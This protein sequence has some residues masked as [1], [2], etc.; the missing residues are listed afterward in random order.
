VYYPLFSFGLLKQKSAS[1]WSPQ[2]T[3]SMVLSRTAARILD[4]IPRERITRLVGRAAERPV[5]STVLNPVLGAYIRAFD[6]NLDEAVVPQDGFASFNDFFTR[7][8]RD[9][10]HAIDQNPDAIVSPSDGRL[11]D[12]GPI[13]GNSHFLVKG[14]PY[15][16]EELLGSSEEA[17]WFEG[18]KYGVVYL[19]PRDYHRVH[20][21]VT[22]TVRRVRH[23]PG[24]LYPVNSI[25]IRH[26][27][28]LF[29]RNER[30]VVYVDTERFGTVAVVFVGAFIVGKISLYFDAP[31]R[32]PH[33][34]SPV[35]RTY[36]S[37]S[38]PRLARGDEMGAF[39]LGSTVVLLLPKSSWRDAP[40][41]PIGPVRMGQPI[42][43]RSAE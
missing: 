39:L 42:A 18:G 3:M 9:G 28:R 41:S 25:G 43:W 23:L 7:K 33:G 5:P 17:R 16:S 36:D 2:I 24:A 11:D 37:S 35:E 27:P 19:S 12:V 20:S 31:K 22:G 30:V 14:Q 1:V 13:D 26:V 4:V 6:V 29:A 38:A 32:P 8:L 40:S 10:V 15:T 21:P 34:G